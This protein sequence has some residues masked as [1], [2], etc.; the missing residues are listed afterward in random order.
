M[1]GIPG[2]NFFEYA[3][4]LETKINIQVDIVDLAIDDRFVNHITKTGKYF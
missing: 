4:I 2:I 3:G 1:E